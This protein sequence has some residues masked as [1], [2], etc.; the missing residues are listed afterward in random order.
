VEIQYAP[1]RS[2]RWRLL[3]RAP[4]SIGSGYLDVRVRVPS[5]GTLRLVWRAPT[6]AVYYSRNAAVSVAR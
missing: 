5:S 4:A 3:A 2:H 1:R 6:G